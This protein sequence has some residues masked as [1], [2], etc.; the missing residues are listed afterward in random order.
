MIV[1]FGTCI[2]KIF[3]HFLLE[4]NKAIDPATT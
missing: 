1:E 4:N 2:P 3:Q